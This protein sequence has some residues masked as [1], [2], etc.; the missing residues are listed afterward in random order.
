[1]R[2][3]QNTR[4]ASRGD[5]P[6]SPHRRSACSLTRCLRQSSLPRA[7]MLHR[8]KQPVVH[9]VENLIVGTTTGVASGIILACFFWLR[10]K[11]SRFLERRNQ[12]HHLR[13]LIDCYGRKILD[14]ETVTAQLGGR[15]VRLEKGQHQRACFD[16]LKRQIAAVLEGRATRLTFDEA[17]SVR[18]IIVG[19]GDLFP[20]VRFN[21]DMYR[22]E[23]FGKLEALD[24]LKPPPHE[25][26][27]SAI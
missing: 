18:T 12:I 16:D 9:M 14:A 23:V 13:T 6:D 8:I 17:N 4:A 7:V 5:R 24:W 27:P 21:D 25:R 26:S 19:L 1:M 11:S 2:A 22:T 3:R 10:G 15:P 20:D